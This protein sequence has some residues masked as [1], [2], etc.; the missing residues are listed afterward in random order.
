M[1]RVSADI[2]G[3]F[4]DIVVEDTSNKNIKTIK[5]LEAGWKASKDN[6]LTTIFL[7]ELGFKSFRSYMP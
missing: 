1:Y 6:A 4:T 5:A 2:G 7:N 3:T